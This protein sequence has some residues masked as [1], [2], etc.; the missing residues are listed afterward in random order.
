MKRL[1]I[2]AILGLFLLLVFLIARQAI[3]SNQASQIL[4]NTNRVLTNLQSKDTSKNLVLRASSESQWLELQDN[5]GNLMDKISS[6]NEFVTDVKWSSDN[7]FLVYAHTNP[8]IPSRDKFLKAFILS[9]KRSIPVATLQNSEV[10]FSLA[11]SGEHLAIITP[12]ELL[13]FS[14]ENNQ[15]FK[16]DTWEVFQEKAGSF[17]VAEPFWSEDG[18]TIRFVQKK[19]LE[20]QVVSATLE[21]SI[22]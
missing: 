15:I 22:Y 21:Y 4:P 19:Y 3:N 16:K 6:P 5:Q 8:D 17:Y 9:E 20:G 10:R 1:S 12:T 11:P 13:L 7:S 2:G 14:F 18:N